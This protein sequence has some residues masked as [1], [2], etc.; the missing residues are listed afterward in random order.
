MASL[1]EKDSLSQEQIDELE[2]H[3][4][5]SM[6]ALQTTGLS[7][8]EAFLIAVRRLGSASD[9]SSAQVR[10]KADRI[11]KDLFTKAEISDATPFGGE[12]GAMTIKGLWNGVKGVDPFLA[13]MVVL[14]FILAML[15]QWTGHD[16]DES[17]A[18]FLNVSWM[19]IPSAALLYLRRDWA[20][21]EREM[22]WIA[23]RVGVLLA[24]L[25]VNLYP[26]ADD[27][28]TL[29]LSI[30]H[31]P[32]LSWLALALFRDSDI[33]ARGE[34]RMDF[35]RFTG[36]ALV[37]SVLVGLSILALIGL[38]AGLFSL[39]GID[40]EPVFEYWIA[41]LIF[42]LT[43][44][45]GIVLVERKRSLVE[46]F[47]PVLAKILTPMLLLVLGIF[48]VALFTTAQ[49]GQAD[50][51]VLILMDLLLLAVVMVVIYGV[52]TR[53]ELE[54][55]PLQ[56]LASLVLVGLAIVCDVYALASM[57]SRLAEFGISAN[58][59][60]ALGGNILLLGN[61]LLLLL[62]FARQLRSGVSG[63][64]LLSVQG[65]Y[66]IAYYIWFAVVA[67]GFPLVFSFS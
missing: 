62:Y 61:L 66:F 50:R 63:E 6:E 27:G 36:E 55:H 25:L 2:S 29:N 13:A 26:F 24:P 39:L 3:L 60:A 5:D 18:Y 30:L 41:P 1:A 56:D 22:R 33:L 16:F 51:E 35:I 48:T 23:I 19:V 53:S 8:E 15:P 65:W 14:T 57:V 9:L 21:G 12:G 47:A 17:P 28:Q 4:L 34:A 20:T 49:F 46:N 52:S 58:K 67:L 38:S 31:L 64:G 45:T 32:F 37:Y 54:H 40:I 7:E 44:L 11:W 42:P 59:L 10:R 43:L